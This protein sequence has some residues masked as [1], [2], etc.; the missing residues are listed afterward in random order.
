VVRLSISFTDGVL[1]VPAA[2]PLLINV[3]IVVLRVGDGL[4]S[5]RMG[6]ALCVAMLPH[7]HVVTALHHAGA[8]RGLLIQFSGDRY[9]IRA[10]ARS[11]LCLPR[12]SP[13]PIPPLYAVAE[14]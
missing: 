6:S 12:L 4:K 2:L 10:R 1:V 13:C 8:K 7:V 14:A 11:I 5:Q 3:T 9:F